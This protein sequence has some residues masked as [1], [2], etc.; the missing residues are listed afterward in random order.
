M[1]AFSSV[2]TFTVTHPTP[3][4]SIC[5]IE[6]GFCSCNLEECWIWF[7]V[8]ILF[9]IRIELLVC[10]LG[11]ISFYR[12]DECVL[13]GYLPLWPQI[14]P[15]CI[16]GSSLLI[17][18]VSLTCPV[19]VDLY[20]FDPLV[21]PFNKIWSFTWTKSVR[22]LFQWRKVKR[23]IFLMSLQEVEYGKAGKPKELTTTTKV[24]KV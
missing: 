6:L 18:G 14:I 17:R 9:D 10:H 8:Q 19:A 1:H 12:F 21:A 11:F 3:H 23:C 16:C 13:Q 15:P 24:Q 2:L 7:T 22:W 4:G 20:F 5:P